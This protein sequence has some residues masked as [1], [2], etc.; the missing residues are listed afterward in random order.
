MAQVSNLRIDVQSGASRLYASW[1]FTAPSGSS[2]S[3][4]GTGGTGGVIK[5]GSIVSIK[6]GATYYNGASMP[7]W[8]QSR[9]WY[10]SQIKGDRAVLGKSVDGIY[11]INSPVNTKYLTAVSSSNSTS[12]S[13]SSTTGGTLDHFEVK[14]SY[15]TGNKDQSGTPIWFTDGT[16]DTTEKTHYIVRQITR[17]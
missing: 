6:S 2:G 16:S 11:N 7:S 4:G 9:R 5:T 3:S 8:V 14:W 12:T 10:V 17:P 1:S 13:T 15:S